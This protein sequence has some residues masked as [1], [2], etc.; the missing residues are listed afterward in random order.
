MAIYNMD[1]YDLDSPV[2]TVNIVPYDTDS[3][4]VRITNHDP[5]R[6]SLDYVQRLSQAIS[7]RFKGEMI[8]PRELETL[9]AD[10]RK[11]KKLSSTR[12]VRAENTTN[13]ELKRL[14]ALTTD[15]PGDS[16]NRVLLPTHPARLQKW[17][18][19][20]EFFKDEV[21]H[22]HLTGYEIA[23]KIKKDTLLRDNLRDCPQGGDTL[24]KIVNAGLAG[25]FDK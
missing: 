13:P 3:I 10:D 9:A 16:D 19:V 5:F 11:V 18:K 6:D 21:V 22:D 20:W 23:A 14:D 4:L 25:L 17:L 12:F 15:R 1:R 8:E 24:Q 2:V 7:T